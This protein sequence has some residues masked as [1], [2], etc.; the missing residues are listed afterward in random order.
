MTT[1]FLDY[2]LRGAVGLT[3][4]AWIGMN[5]YDLLYRQARTEMSGA[6]VSEGNV[7]NNIPGELQVGEG[8]GGAG[9]IPNAYLLG[10]QPDQQYGQS[11]VQL[12]V[13]SDKLSL[14]QI[15]ARFNIG[16]RVRVP[17]SRAC[18]ET[19]MPGSCKV[20]LEEITKL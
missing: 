5:G 14:S 15:E 20:Q 7:G 18:F 11:W 17:V 2:C 13:E 19:H 1:T 8:C 9:I 16:D 6:I 3:A 12:Q 4:A 10:F